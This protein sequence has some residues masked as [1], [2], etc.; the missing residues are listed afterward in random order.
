MVRSG[1]S[2][3][4]VE[5]KHGKDTHG[6]ITDGKENKFE[7]PS[8]GVRKKHHMRKKTT[9]RIAKTIKLHSES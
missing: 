5:D 3:T 2:Y 9:N 6:N 4:I 7:I 8:I 1:E